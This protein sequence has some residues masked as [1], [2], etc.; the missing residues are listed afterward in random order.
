MKLG[1]HGRLENFRTYTDQY[2]LHSLD[3]GMFLLADTTGVNG[4]GGL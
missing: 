3:S 4:Y 1:K 2:V